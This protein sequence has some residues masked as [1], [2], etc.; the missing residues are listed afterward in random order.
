MLSRVLGR[1]LI[2]GCLFAATSVDGQR[3]GGL[4]KAVGSPVNPKVPIFWNRYYDTEA[5]ETLSR[6]IVR[7]Y[8][9]L[10]KWQA[11]G[12]SHQGRRIWCLTITDFGKGSP[13]R[14]PATYIQGNIHGNEIQGGEFALYTA[15][16]L[17]ESFADT[18]Y[19]RDLLADKV[20]YIVPTI[21]PDSRDYFIH[22]PTNDQSPRGYYTANGPGFNDLDRDG[23]ITQMRI[24]NPKGVWR[25]D[26]KNPLGMIRLDQQ[27]IIRVNGVETAKAPD[28]GN[29]DLLPEGAVGEL[30]GTGL[31]DEKDDPNRNWGFG[32]E[33]GRNTTP[34][35]PFTFPETKAVRDFFLAHPN[36]AVAESFHNNGGDLVPATA[37]RERG[38]KE[39]TDDSDEDIRIYNELA[40]HG[41]EVLP[42]YKYVELFKNEGIPSREVDWMFA[43]RGAYSFISELMSGMFHDP[44]THERNETYY[45]FN[46][47]LLFGD[48]IVPWHE[49]ISP[50]FGRVEVGGAKKTYGRLDPGFLLEED[51]HRNMA[52]SLYLSY[53]TPK[54]LVKD[55]TVKDV[56]NG[57]QEV[58]TIIANTRLLPTHSGPDL[59]HNIARPDYITLKT[60]AKVISATQIDSVN[61]PDIKVIKE[62][63]DNPQRFEIDNIPGHSSIIVRWT[64]QGIG[65][66]TVTLYSV[67][68]GAVSASTKGGNRFPPRR[69]GLAVFGNKGNE[70]QTS[71]C[72]TP[73]GYDLSVRGRLLDRDYSARS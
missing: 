71:Y 65:P 41:E 48:A 18:K 70:T 26:P 61:G 3:A 36:I 34:W 28:A 57:L 16:Y 54:L 43:K 22:K 68:G 37:K 62:Q 17:T 6:K 19:I 40:K 66:Y 73:S 20:F 64:V 50:I 1:I 56:G 44:K 38:K 15:W 9:H 4:L 60:T 13:I 23:S 42:A 59:S 72:Y 46:D 32:W 49:V 67:K 33:D 55:I 25:I 7:A 24:K 45:T 30:K 8:P 31:D 29:Y 5:L 52:F 47:D 51:A 69:A 39:D 14:K 35:L 2:C 10:A 53:E 21:N 27:E 58:T 63:K 12:K 11:I